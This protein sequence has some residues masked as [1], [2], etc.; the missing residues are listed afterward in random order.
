MSTLPSELWVSFT[1]TGGVVGVS[2]EEK[3]TSQFPN[4]F[5]LR[6][7]VDPAKSRRVTVAYTVREGTEKKKGRYLSGSAWLG[8]IWVDKA[9][10]I[11]ESPDF[12]RQLAET[13]KARGGRVVALRR[14]A[15]S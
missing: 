10:A 14:T 3:G 6:Y 15:T 5:S 8:P 11:R 12:K 2:A 4:C 13:A 1:V 9:L 7:I